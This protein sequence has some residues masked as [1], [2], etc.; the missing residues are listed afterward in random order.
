MASPLILERRA[1]SVRGTVQGVGFRPFVFR[2]AARWKLTG[3]VQNHAGGVRIEV[4][5]EP[6]ALDRFLAEIATDA[7]PR[8]QV[9]QLWWEP[10]PPR[11][12]RR[13]RIAQS[14]SAATGRIVVSP[15]I[16]TC[17]RCLR[18]L[19]DPADRR[20]RHP[21]INCTNCGPRLTIVT[22]APY[23]RPRTTMARFDMCPRCQ[24]EYHDPRDR[25]FH[26]QPIACPRCGP[27]LSLL[28]AQGHK[29][30]SDDPLSDFAQALLAGKIGALKGIGGYHLVC[31]ARQAAVVA[32]LRRRKHRDEKPLALMVADLAHAREICLVDR[33]EEQ[34]LRSP[35]R[36]IVLLR[37]RAGS[38]IAAEVAPANPLLGIMLPYSALHH[39]L[40][41][42]TGGAP[43]VMTSGN[44][45]DEPIA[46]EEEDA[47]HRLSG[48]ADLF[49]V[50]D[51]P[52]AV[53]CDD[54]VVR[55]IDGLATPLRRSRGFAPRPIDLPHPSPQ[56]IL[57]VGG[58]LKVTFALACDGQAVL[59][60]H[61]GDLGDYRAYQAFETD[62]DL[63]QRLFAIR[64]VCI[65][66][67][68]HPDY[69]S[70]YYA[71]R[72]QTQAGHRCLAVQ[73]HHAHVASC[74]AEHRLRGAVIGVAF[75]GSGLGS[76]GAVWG[77]EFFV[78]DYRRF[79]RAAHLR[80]VGMPG[81]EQAIR[82]PWRMAAAHLLD[83]GL[84]LDPLA[85]RIPAHL[86]RLVE[87]LLRRGIH[88]PPTSSVGRL[89]DAVAS[90][91]GLRDQV[92]FEGQAAME[93]EWHADG[94]V[95]A[96]AYPYRLD[97]P[98]GG[99]LVI[100]TRPLVR[101]IVGDLAGRVGVGRIAQRFH[102]TIAEIVVGVCRRL[103]DEQHLN[104]VVLSGGV[105]QN[106][107]LTAEVCRR[108]AAERFES[109]RHRLVPPGDGGLSLG[110][111]AIAAAQ[112]NCQ[113]L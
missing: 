70:T 49:L 6:E 88:A 42:A 65:A 36:P 46:Y 87:T 97:Q 113:N 58:Q 95:S 56:P 30:A 14:D 78:G 19:A 100:D 92:S 17:D 13:F 102:G 7:P 76:D 61:L 86:L 62:I 35:P 11:G 69:A 26:A 106:A 101:A 85:P 109:F 57:A 52:I 71:L 104:R 53:R 1:I 68:L 25:R 91:A 47:L 43:L 110:Q 81:G 64:P 48:V 32:A 54:S 93:L 39:L 28:D 50:H 111:V 34:L 45:S 112:L 31:D 67:D 79:R 105:F 63:Y 20:H 40:L 41:Q 80:C 12:E 89:F 15:D 18:E 5:G 21:F 75:D 51:R 72:R 99:P 74:M 96:D 4:E 84:S 38:A 9:E 27:R 22:G 73:H 59:S 10:L 44:Q 77:G 108:L 23:D 37:K 55:V 16:A 98:P 2:L 29:L 107:L 24:A 8:A 66:H 3:F 82:Q 60:H 83:A 103:R 94:Q 33:A 90:L